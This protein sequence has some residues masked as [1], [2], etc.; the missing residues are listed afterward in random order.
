MPDSFDPYKVLHGTHRAQ[1]IHSRIKP[2]VIYKTYIEVIDIQDKGKMS[3]LVT[4]AKSYEI[5]EN[6]KQDLAFINTFGSLLM[7]VGGF[8]FSGTK[9]AK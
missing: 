6:G 9:K 7:G 5:L 8:G 1:M 2:N 3:V 4:E